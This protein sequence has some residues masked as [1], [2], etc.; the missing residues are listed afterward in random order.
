MVAILRPKNTILYYTPPT[1]YFPGHHVLAADNQLD[2]DQWIEA[3]KDAVQ[4]DRIHMRRKKTQSMVVKRAGD[5]YPTAS[6]GRGYA[7]KLDSGAN[8]Y[9]DN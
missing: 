1:H 5:E 9:K 8:Q 4:D 2:M 3:I 7:S 6:V